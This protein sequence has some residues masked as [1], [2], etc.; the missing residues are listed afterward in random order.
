MFIV[1]GIRTSLGKCQSNEFFFPFDT[2]PIPSYFVP[3]AILNNFTN[4][5]TSTQKHFIFRA[6]FPPSRVLLRK[7]R[8]NAWS[9][10]C[11]QL[12]YFNLTI[13]IFPSQ[14]GCSR[15]LYARTLGRLY[16]NSSHST[17][18]IPLCLRQKSVHRQT[19]G[20]MKPRMK[21][22]ASRCLTDKSV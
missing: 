14:Y 12:F 19:V 17:Q 20:W 2:L 10:A 6:E 22:A 15:K 9:D 8:S 11:A 5:C 13:I 16:Q 7:M 3:S 1:D 21:C 4:T 18:H